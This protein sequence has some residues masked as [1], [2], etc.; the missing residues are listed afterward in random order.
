MP[1]S[2]DGFHA[3]HSRYDRQ[4]G[5]LVYYWTCERC[6]TRLKEAR[7]EPYRPQFDP[8]GN[9]PFLAATAR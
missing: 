4:D 7:R 6:G 1:C 3:I 5:L 8:H 2:H 9:D